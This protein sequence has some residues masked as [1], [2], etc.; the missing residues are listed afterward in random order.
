MTIFNFLPGWKTYIVGTGMIFTALGAG[1]A[2][3]DFG[4]FDWQLFMEGLAIMTLRK[5][6]DNA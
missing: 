4:Q 3:G 5:G 6:M 1:L 2:S